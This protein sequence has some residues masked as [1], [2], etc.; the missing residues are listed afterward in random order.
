MF[1]S[2]FMKLLMRHGLNCLRKLDQVLYQRPKVPNKSITVYPRQYT[3]THTPSR[4]KIGRKYPSE[5]YLN[6]LV[7]LHRKPPLAHP[8]SNLT[9]KN[10]NRQNRPE[11]RRFLVV[12]ACLGSFMCIKARF[13]FRFGKELL[14]TAFANIL[15]SISKI[16]FLSS[17]VSVSTHNFPP[18]LNYG[19]LIGFLSHGLKA[20][21]A[22]IMKRLEEF[23]GIVL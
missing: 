5:Y 18:L 13:Y 12:P 9:L 15:C 4:D 1:I 14:L 23:S 10:T 8:Q 2:P 21:L 7:F 19:S 17:L 16:L 20:T 3:D 22:R 6:N 11:L